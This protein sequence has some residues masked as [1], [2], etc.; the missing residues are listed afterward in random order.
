[1]GPIR[2]ELRGPSGPEPVEGSEV[3]DGWIGVWIA[4]DFR[5]E[6]AEFIVKRIFT[7]LDPPRF[8]AAIAFVGPPVA[9]RLQVILHIEGA[10][11]CED[12]DT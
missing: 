1:M 7:H 10:V 8:R 3:L 6:I 2:D 9:S 4:V 12:T 5:S 11:L